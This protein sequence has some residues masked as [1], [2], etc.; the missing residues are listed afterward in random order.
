MCRYSKCIFNALFHRHSATFGSKG[1][2]LYITE[3][4]ARD[5]NMTVE[6]SAVNRFIS[7]GDRFALPPPVTE[8]T[9][10]RLL[11]VE[12]ASWKEHHDMLL[13]S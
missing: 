10:A 12:A 7:K 9:M 6:F 13:P 3:L 11:A 8:E 5:L 1:L 4:I 2:K